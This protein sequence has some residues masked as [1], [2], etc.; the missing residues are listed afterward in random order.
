GNLLQW[1]IASLFIESEP[2]LRVGA[3]EDRV[4]YTARQAIDR[5]RITSYPPDADGD[6]DQERR[7][8]RQPNPLDPML[9]PAERAQFDPPEGWTQDAGLGFKHWRRRCD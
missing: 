9:R 4:A 7:Q 5:D 8:E 1:D 3:V 2:R 6:H